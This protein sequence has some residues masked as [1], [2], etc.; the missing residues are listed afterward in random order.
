[1]RRLV[2]LLLMIVSPMVLA[3]SP[4]QGELIHFD[5]VKLELCIRVMDEMPSLVSE[6]E[7]CK[8]VDL[9]AEYLWSKINVGGYGTYKVLYGLITHKDS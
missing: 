5:D 2:A 6:S 8:H 4:V 9:H 3:E 7:D 1:M